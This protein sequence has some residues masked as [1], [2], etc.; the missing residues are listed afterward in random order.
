MMTTLATI[1]LLMLLTTL[2]AVSIKHI[3][4]GQIGTLRRHHGRDLHLLQPGTHV[5]LPLRDRLVHRISVTGRVLQLDEPCTRM[6]GRRL[7]GAIYWQVLEPILVD[8]IIDDVTELIRHQSIAVIDTMRDATDNPGGDWLKERL[9][10]T[11]KTRGVLIT[12]VNLAT[13]N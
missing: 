9:N 6:P 12:R 1:G 8:D 2:L 5:L 3:P 13:G 10:A 7:R 4:E 11:L